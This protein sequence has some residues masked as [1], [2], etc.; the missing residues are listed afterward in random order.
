MVDLSVVIPAF[1]EQ[2]RIGASVESVCR[3]LR[4]SGRSW[5]L[6]IVDDGSTDRT[7]AIATTIAAREPG[8][9][10]IRSPRN[11][12][13]G[14]ALRTGVLASRGAEVLVSDA[15]LSTPISEIER[16]RAARNG[17]VA[18]IG[19][20]FHRATIGVRQSRLRETLGRLGNLAIRAVAVRGISD[21][22]CGFKLFSGPQ[23]RVLFGM[24]RLNGWAIDVEILHLCARLGWQVAEVPVRWSH[25]AGSKLR[26]GAYLHVLAELAYLRV[27]H[28]Q[29]REPWL[30]GRS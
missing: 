24:A 13:K 23:A 6:I 28:R 18:A 8:I 17:A 25:A 15:D 4:R 2:D 21:T 11:A 20:R 1:N 26:P 3:Y 16:L 12:G 9:R 27:A 7:A 22:Q 30:A 10:L 14:H 5:E 29:A 19:S